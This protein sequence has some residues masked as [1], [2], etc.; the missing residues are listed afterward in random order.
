MQID[1]W[2]QSRAVFGHTFSGIVWHI[3]HRKS[4]IYATE[5]LSYMPQKVC[6]ICHRKSVIYATESLSYIPQK[7]WHIC[8]RNWIS[9]WSQW[10]PR[11]E[12]VSVTLHYIHNITHLHIKSLIN[13]N[14]L[15]N[16]IDYLWIL[17]PLVSSVEHWFHL[18]RLH[19]HPHQVHHPNPAS[20]SIFLFCFSFQDCQLNHPTEQKHKNLI[21][22]VSYHNHRLLCI[23]LSMQALVRQPF[24]NN[25][26]NNK[27]NNNNNN[28]LFFY[29]H[30]VKPE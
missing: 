16:W 12:I 9:W 29:P 21:F 2:L 13:Q 17:S 1:W 18:F 7:V 14:Q 23:L 25:D 3:C 15:I 11:H 28:L 8:H 10:W 30:P 20:L 5:S 26:N 4:V 24:P 19:L 6:H 22:Y 27:N